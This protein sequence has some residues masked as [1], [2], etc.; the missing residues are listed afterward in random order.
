MTNHA[1][2]LCF[3]PQPVKPAIFLIPGGMAEAM[4]FQ[5]RVMIQLHVQAFPPDW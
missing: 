5:N 1:S 3:F 2:V 4:P